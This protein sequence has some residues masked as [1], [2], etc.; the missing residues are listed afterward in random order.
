MGR[1]L[2]VDDDLAMSALIELHL[3][4]AGHSVQVANSARD[5]MALAAAPETPEVV[6]LDVA[7]PDMSGFELLRGLRR[8]DELA[9]VR[10]VFLSAR[11]TALDIEAG[12]RMGA[13]YLT[14]PFIASALLMAVD[15]LIED[16][17]I[18]TCARLEERIAERGTSDQPVL[19]SADERLVLERLTGGHKAP[20][21]LRAQSLLIQASSHAGLAG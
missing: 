12:Q 3:Q 6:V 18:A 20:L 4:R 15:R 10:A 2:V 8:I 9:S 1:V 11:I 14:K 21:A 16:G 5:A 7:M 19:I 13:I 17:A